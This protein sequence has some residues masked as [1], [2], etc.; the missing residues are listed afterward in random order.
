MP[1]AATSR[2]DRS[3]AGSSDGPTAP[4]AE[5]RASR[6]SCRR[7]APAATMALPT[8][9]TA[10]A[11]C[12][13]R[14]SRSSPS[15]V[16]GDGP[17]LNSQPQR[18]AR[19]AERMVKVARR[20]SS[21]H[22]P[23]PSPISSARAARTA[24]R[25]ASTKMSSRGFAA[26]DRADIVEPVRLRV[27]EDRVQPGR[28]FRA[29]P[30]VELVEQRARP[31]RRRTCA[32]TAHLRTGDR[33][34]PPARPSTCGPSRLQLRRARRWPPL[35][36]RAAAPSSDAPSSTCEHICSAARPVTSFCHAVALLT[37]TL[38]AA[39]SA[40]AAASRETAPPSRA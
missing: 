6:P 22:V 14:A 24:S 1:H 11:G 40:A 18:T 35:R 39:I 10:A 32:A 17:R 5:P 38:V 7:R 12:S 4:S 15:P 21:L 36:R 30:L 31:S 8:P 27:V 20:A 13:S 29:R 2:S 34:P 33:A 16:I 26:I 3:S 9:Q 25:A 37:P 28:P 23:L 19:V